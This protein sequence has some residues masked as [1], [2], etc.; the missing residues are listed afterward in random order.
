MQADWQYS[1]WKADFDRDGFVVVPQFLPAEELETLTGN[2]ER[3]IRDVV[4][5]LSDADAFYQNRTRP[6]TLKQLQHM[7]CDPFFDAYRHNPR[8]T[9]LAATLVGEP[10][11]GMEPEWFNK[12]PGAQ[13]PTPPHQDNFYF[14]LRPPHVVSLWLALDRVDEENGCLRYVPG[15]HLRG[16]RPHRPTSILGFSQGVSDYG[17]EDEHRER[18]VFLQPGDLLAHHGETIHRADPNR[19]RDRHRR[20]FAM[21]YRGVSCRRDPQA[22]ERYEEAMRE[23]HRQMGLLNLGE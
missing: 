13:H 4:P 9:Q 15:S 17:P 20:A 12:P 19:T 6:E 5:T 16:L 21:V 10:V 14:C 22:Y 2:I 11:E 23:Q 8:W 3:Y 1:Q 7:A 18:A